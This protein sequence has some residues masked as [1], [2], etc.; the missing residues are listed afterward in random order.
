M[1]DP[2]LVRGAEHVNSVP[3]DDLGSCPNKAG[4]LFNVHCVAA[5]PR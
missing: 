3:P 2:P 4:V 5:I 1:R